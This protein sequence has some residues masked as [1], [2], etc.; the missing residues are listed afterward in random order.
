MNR[1]E[2]LA[3]AAALTVTPL[4]GC[5]R[6][7]GSSDRPEAEPEPGP[8]EIPRRVLGRTGEPVSILGI[9]GWHMGI[10]ALSESEAIRIVR[11]AL[12]A[13]V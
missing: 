7:G 11:T 10:P 2:F 12:D 9:G 13:G 1:R 4:L 6:D 8:G 3:A 5:G